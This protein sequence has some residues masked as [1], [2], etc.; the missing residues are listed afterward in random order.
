MVFLYFFILRLMGE[1]NAIKML[2]LTPK[3]AKLSYVIIWC[4][5]DRPIDPIVLKIVN[6]VTHTTNV[7]FIKFENLL[8]I[9]IKQILKLGLDSKTAM[10]LI[11][12]LQILIES[13]YW[14]VERRSRRLE[15]SQEA[16]D[17]WRN[18]WSSWQKILE[19]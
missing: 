9:L 15:N 11:C 14:C 7:S 4:P 6:A 13:Y 19:S 17:W 8:F 10:N 12:L 16:G 1:I 2:L 3:W 5:Q 18:A